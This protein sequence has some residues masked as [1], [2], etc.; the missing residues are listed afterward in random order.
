MENLEKS[1]NFSK[2][3]VVTLANIPSHTYNIFSNIEKI[4]TSLST[5]KHKVSNRPLRM[6]VHQRNEE[7]REPSFPVVSPCSNKNHWPT[8]E[9][10]SSS[11]DR[12]SRATSSSW[13]GDMEEAATRKVLQMWD[14]IEKNLFGEDDQEQSFDPV[15]DE[16]NQWK[17]QLIHLR[18]IGKSLNPS[19]I[20]ESNEPSRSS[21]RKSKASDDRF[22]EEIIVEDSSYR[23]QDS[24][25]STRYPRIEDE[26]NEVFDKLL[27]FVCS[28]LTKQDETND[29]EFLG[30]DL[31]DVLRITPAPTYSGSKSLKGRKTRDNPGSRKTSA[32]E[33]RKIVAAAVDDPRVN[34]RLASA[35]SKRTVKSTTNGDVNVNKDEPVVPQVARNKLGTVFNEK[36][37][38]S[39][40]PFIVSTRESFTTLRTTP[41]S[42]RAQTFE[43]STPQGKI[44]VFT[45]LRRAFI[46]IILCD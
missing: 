30:T 19:A 5:E 21:S 39:P 35:A 27:E 14:A 6:T 10:D 7:S 28:E 8:M 36:I 20:Q 26:Q 17:T 11:W 12:N 44:V 32:N 24:N 34:D 9:N 46:Y 43:I 1:G 13:P 23:T 4:I 40:V 16:C 15:S 3:Y 2:Q 37:V 31:D 18:V 33:D 22:G 41:I 45:R 29:A 42:F 38:V 25:S